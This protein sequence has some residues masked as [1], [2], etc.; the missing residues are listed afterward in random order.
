MRR[1]RTVA[2]YRAIDLVIFAALLALFEFVLCKAG[3][4]WYSREA[5]VIS[6]TPLFT[7]V[8]MMR[9]GVW[10]GIH[11]LLGGVLWVVF[12]GMSL[13]A[14]WENYLIYGIGNLGGLAGL[15]MLKKPSW[16]AVRDS[17]W[18]TLA[19]G[20]VVLLGMMTG[21]ALIAW[22]LGALPKTLILFYT[23]EVVTALFTLVALWIVRRLDGM[24]ENQL[25][26]LKRVHREMQSEEE[27]G[28]E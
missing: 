22:I 21:R 27:G 15:A 3:T 12:Y 7:A 14:G 6:L 9:W 17:A 13:G 26:Y 18:L 2:Q 20:A 25:H 5:Y 8:V 23:P 24:F 4:V 19:Y 1:Q 16:K 10:G 11:A 28:S